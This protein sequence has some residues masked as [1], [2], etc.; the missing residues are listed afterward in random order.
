MNLR[1]HEDSIRALVWK[2]CSVPSNIRKA[3]VE[4]LKDEDVRK[5]VYEWLGDVK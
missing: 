5:N 2:W 4:W 3:V 1:E